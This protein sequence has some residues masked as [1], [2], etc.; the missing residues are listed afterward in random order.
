MEEV[1]IEKACSQDTTKTNWNISSISL[2]TGETPLTS[3]LTFSGVVLKDKSSLILDLN[4]DLGEIIYFYTPIKQISAGF[5][6]GFLYNT[7]WF[8]PIAS[9]NLL[10]GHITTLNWIGW[11]AG[12]P[13]RGNTSEKIIFCFS[14]QQF[15]LNWKDFQAYYV[16]LHYQKNI[17]EHIFG[18]TGTLDFNEKVSLFGGVG[19]MYNED[20]VLWSTGFKYNF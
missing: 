7:P 11:S 13:E 6:G 16:L 19:Y 2:C 18:M 4:N 9:F 20:K 12:D 8:G 3:G 5:S 1:V 14:Y 10:D 15:N 17:P